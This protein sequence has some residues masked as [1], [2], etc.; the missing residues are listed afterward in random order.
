MT[1]SAIYIPASAQ[2]RINQAPRSSKPYLSDF[3]VLAL[4]TFYCAWKLWDLGGRY[5]FDLDA[6]NQ[7]KAITQSSGCRRSH[8]IEGNKILQHAKLITCEDGRITSVKVYAC[9]KRR[10]Q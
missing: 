5:I 2:E 9:P 1:Q 7:R 10:G 3:D 8:V 4:Y 6:E